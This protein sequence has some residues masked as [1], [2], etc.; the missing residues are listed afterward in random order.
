MLGVNR[1]PARLACVRHAASVHP[2]PGSNPQINLS[3]SS[4]QKKRFAFLK[5]RF[6]PNKFGRL[7]YSKCHHHFHDVTVLVSTFQRVPHNSLC[8]LL[9]SYDIQISMSNPVSRSA[10]RTVS[11]LLPVCVPLGGQPAYHIRTASSCQGFL[12]GQSLLFNRFVTASDCSR[13]R[14]AIITRPANPGQ[15]FFEIKVSLFRQKKT[16]SQTFIIWYAAC[17]D[18]HKCGMCLK[19]QFTSKTADGTSNFHSTPGTRLMGCIWNR[20]LFLHPRCRDHCTPPGFGM[21]WISRR[22]TPACGIWYRTCWPQ[23]RCLLPAFFGCLST[24]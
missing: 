15:A 6:L 4:L 17:L 2:E 18:T 3:V 5:I 9:C 10:F 13:R 19:C 22:C 1:H 11:S 7:N 12:F 23:T 21:R 20:D 24:V 14:S 16:A 8:G